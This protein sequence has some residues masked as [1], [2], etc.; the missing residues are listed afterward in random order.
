M[1]LFIFLPLILY[2]VMGKLEPILADIR[3]EVE[4]TLHRLLINHTANIWDTHTKGQFKD[5]NEVN[6]SHILMLLL[7]HT[8]T[9]G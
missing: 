6:V 3:W 4:Y 7:L 8:I 9:A 2:I 1:Y 5:T